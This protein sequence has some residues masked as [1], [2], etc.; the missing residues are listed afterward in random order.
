M[1]NGETQSSERCAHRTIFQRCARP[2]DGRAYVSLQWAGFRTVQLIMTSPAA[3]ARHS[4]YTTN[5][6][7][8]SMTSRVSDTDLRPLLREYELACKG[9]P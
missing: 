7:A 9:I 3:L 2:T 6:I 8:V 4:R 5:L 1:Q